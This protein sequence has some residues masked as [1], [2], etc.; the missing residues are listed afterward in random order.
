MNADGAINVTDL[1]LLANHILGHANEIF[2][3][4]NADINRDEKITVTDV[5]KLVDMIFNDIQ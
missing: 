4:E 1:M 5:M 2:I 3:E